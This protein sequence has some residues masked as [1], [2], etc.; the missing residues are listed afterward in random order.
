[1]IYIFCF[2][3]IKSFLGVTGVAINTINTLGVALGVALVTPVTP[4]NLKKV[5][6]VCYFPFFIFSTITDI[7]YFSIFYI[8][9]NHT[10]GIIRME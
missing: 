7:I 3:K 8:N 1:M 6:F 5:F 9:F 10:L 2:S 4:N